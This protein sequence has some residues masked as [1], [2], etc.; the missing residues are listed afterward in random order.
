MAQVTRGCMY[1]ALEI[2]RIKMRRQ[3][4]H[5]SECR[6]IFIC[7]L[8]ME[9]TMNKDDGKRISGSVAQAGGAADF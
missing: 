3:Y 7:T 6:R 9:S 4:I 2:P 8:V 1:C 5:Y